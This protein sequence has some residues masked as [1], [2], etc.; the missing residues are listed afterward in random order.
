[1]VL[2]HLL[3]S[4]GVFAQESD[5]MDLAIYNA[6]LLDTISAEEEYPVQYPDNPQ[7]F[8][9]Y[10]D[11]VL[12]Q[13]VVSS[14]SSA[15]SYYNEEFTTPMPPPKPRSDKSSQTSWSGFQDLNSVPVN[16]QELEA[17][18]PDFAKAYNEEESQLQAD[19]ADLEFV[20]QSDFAVLNQDG[21]IESYG[22]NEELQDVVYETY[23]VSYPDYEEYEQDYVQEPELKEQQGFD[24][25]QGSGPTTLMLFNIFSPEEVDFLKTLVG[26]EA[27]NELKDDVDVPTVKEDEI[28]QTLEISTP[29]SR[30][31]PQFNLNSSGSKNAY[32]SSQGIV[33]PDL[34]IRESLEV[35]HKSELQ[36][37]D[38]AGDLEEEGFLPLQRQ[39]SIPSFEEKAASV[40][41]YSPLMRDIE[42]EESDSPPIVE[43]E[44]DQSEKKGL[45]AKA[46]ER[47]VKM[48]ALLHKLSERYEKKKKEDEDAVVKSMED[49]LDEEIEETEKKTNRMKTMIENLKNKLAQS[50][51]GVNN[52]DTRDLDLPVRTD[53]P[54]DEKRYGTTAPPVH[55]DKVSEMIGEKLR[56]LHGGIHN[57][58]LDD[59]LDLDNIQIKNKGEDSNIP[60]LPVP[61][62]GSEN[63][64]KRQVL[65]PKLTRQRPVS[66]KTHIPSINLKAIITPP[67]EA[68]NLS[69]I[70]YNKR[71]IIP[72]Y[73]DEPIP[74]PQP[75]TYKATEEDT[76]IKYLP[77]RQGPRLKGYKKKND[78]Y[79]ETKELPKNPY[80]VQYEE[81]TE[82]ENPTPQSFNHNE[83]FEDKTEKS[84]ELPP[85]LFYSDRH[86]PANFN[87]KVGPQ[88]MP[89]M[90]ETVPHLEAYDEH[91]FHGKYIPSNTYRNQPIYKGDVEQSLRTSKKYAPSSYTKYP[92][93]SYNYKQPNIRFDETPTKAPH[94]QVTPKNVPKTS[95]L[96]AGGL[97][98]TYAQPNAEYVQFLNT[99][100]PKELPTR[101]YAPPPYRPPSYEAKTPDYYT[102]PANQEYNGV[103]NPKPEHVSSL[104]PP[105]R[106][107]V[108]PVGQRTKPSPPQKPYH[109]P[110]PS[111][112]SKIYQPRTGYVPPSSGNYISALTPPPEPSTPHPHVSS[113]SPP[114]KQYLPPK[115]HVST[116]M[117]PPNSKYSTP[118][119]SYVSSISPPKY[120]YSTPQP[121]YHSTT[122][123]TKGAYGKPG[124]SHL[125]SM[126]P[127]RKAYASH[128]L[129]MTPPSN[130]YK[131]PSYMSTMQPP[132]QV[133]ENPMYHSM[134]EMKP[135]S[136]SYQAGIHDH[137]TK[138]PPPSKN[139][140]SPPD[141]KMTK[142]TPPTGDYSSLQPNYREAMKPP[143]ESYDSPIKDDLT[144]NKPP[145]KESY[146]PPKKNYRDPIEPPH[147]SY[148]DGMKGIMSKLSL[149]EQEFLQ[150]AMS[151]KSYL[152]PSKDYKIPDNI[153]KEKPPNGDYMETM[154][155]YMQKPEKLPKNDYKAPDTLTKDFP[156]SKDYL[157]TMY[158]YLGEMKKPPKD[159]YHA[160]HH[161]TKDHHPTKSDYID[162]MFKYLQDINIPTKDYLPPKETHMSPPSESYNAPI[163][164]YLS[165][166][167]LPRKGYLP[168]DDKPTKY[169]PPSKGYNDA[170]SEYLGSLHAPD[171]SYLPPKPKG[172]YMKPPASSY[173]EPLNEYMAK[174][175]A[176]D[177]GYLPP[178][179]KGVHMKPPASSYEKPF[180]DHMTRL[181]V[182]NKDYLPPKQLSGFLPELA[183]YLSPISE[184][185]AS[186][187]PPKT[188]YSYKE[189]QKPHATGYN[190]PEKVNLRPPSREYLT[191]FRP[192]SSPKDPRLLPMVPPREVYSAPQPKPRVPT[193]VRT[194]CPYP[195]KDAKCEY[196]KHQCWSPGTP[197]VDCPGSGL[198]CFNGCV[199]VCLASPS[200]SQPIF[201][202]FHT[203]PNNA[204]LVPGQQN[205]YLQALAS[206][207]RNEEGTDALSDH[208]LPPMYSLAALDTIEI[209]GLPD[210]PEVSQL[211]R[212]KLEKANMVPPAKEYLP[213]SNYPTPIDGYELPKY[214]DVEVS[215][216]KRPDVNYLPPSLDYQI[217][218]G[219]VNVVNGFRVPSEDYLPPVKISKYSPPASSYK[220][221]KSIE[222]FVPPSNEYLPPHDMNKY[223]PPS[224]PY[225][226]PNR[227]GKYSPP[228]KEYLPPKESLKPP[229]S[230]Y[231][232]PVST[233][234]K[235]IH[236]A[237]GGIEAAFQP[238]SGDYIA[239][240]VPTIIKT[241][242]SEN[243][244]LVSGNTFNPPSK[245]YIPPALK[246]A[247]PYYE[248]ERAVF[249]PPSE[250]YLAPQSLFVEDNFHEGVHFQIPSEEY[251]S[252]HPEFKPVHREHGLMTPPE[253]DYSTPVVPSKLPHGASFAPPSEQYV[254]P[255]TPHPKPHIHHEG[256]YLVPPG[257]E[258]IAPHP[259]DPITH[260][261]PSTFHAHQEHAIFHPPV[262]EY[263]PPKMIVS[264]E[265]ATF[266]PPASEYASPPLNHQ[267]VDPHR[268]KY[269]LD[270]TYKPPSKEYLPPHDYKPKENIP[271]PPH[272]HELPHGDL[273]TLV[274]PNKDYLPPPSNTIE[275]IGHGIHVS[276]HHKHHIAVPPALLP[277]NEHKHHP[278]SP[279][280]LTQKE[281]HHDLLSPV[282]HD[283]YH[284]TATIN[285]DGHIEPHHGVVSKV[286][287]HTINIQINIPDKNKHG[288]VHHELPT[289][290]RTSKPPSYS[291]KSPEKH[292]EEV[293]HD[294]KLKEGYDK[295]MPHM[296]PHDFHEGHKTMPHMLPHEHHHG[297]DDHHEGRYKSGPPPTLPHYVPPPLS[298]KYE[299]GYKSPK[300]LDSEYLPP[301]QYLPSHHRLPPK[302]YLPTNPNIYDEGYIKPSYESKVP[303]RESADLFNPMQTLKPP[304]AEFQSPAELNAPIKPDTYLPPDGNRLN[305][306]QKDYLPPSLTKDREVEALIPNPP[307]PE[308]LPEDL[309]EG[310]EIDDGLPNRG[311]QFPLQQKEKEYARPPPRPGSL[312]IVIEDVL[313]S[314][315]NPPIEGKEMYIP[316]KTRFDVPKNFIRPD[317]LLIA[318]PDPAFI[319][320]DPDNDVD[321][322]D[323]I[324]V[325]DAEELPEPPIPETVPEQLTEQPF[326]GLAKL[327]DPERKKSLKELEDLR[328][329]V[330]KLAKLVEDKNEG[331]QLP[332]IPTVP[333]LLTS[334]QLRL[335]PQPSSFMPFIEKLEPSVLQQLQSTVR[336]QNTRD[337]KIPGKPGV[338]YPDFKTIPATDFSCENFLLEG[339]YADTF[340]SCQVSSFSA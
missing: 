136:T 259:H 40:A 245:E 64:P 251:I 201:S 273:P 84:D 271:A 242:Q 162:T 5:K 299:E 331:P 131:A 225:S 97:S 98:S 158:K 178:K 231:L 137:M 206:K 120:G 13:T 33:R 90:K 37:Q 159:E 38:Q 250:E 320:N 20:D 35:Y 303:D 296:L 101:S 238:P 286:G 197:D 62:P 248:K 272:P 91:D 176:P 125:S 216:I 108:P 327:I 19:L 281:P 31:P 42:I 140:Y 185:M 229:T 106:G 122:K 26:E 59:M 315:V 318:P 211:P 165:S 278:H 332:P 170:M 105:A 61:P 175:H 77:P 4:N 116:T 189:V 23:D 166:M 144:Q 129:A 60:L 110:R 339:F 100:V 58:D 152:P 45:L 290:F 204:Y 235:P 151:G 179:S 307:V 257:K 163:S 150:Q 21:S 275:E 66:G 182:P 283:D 226:V 114:R 308:D 219:E 243:F 319:D 220:A 164:D 186:M 291:K 333:S 83:H 252:P 88:A 27:V 117:I 54:V 51:P 262:K 266:K 123:P 177:S 293:H 143:S 194:V 82:Y 267:I 240:K 213:P 295:V 109:S 340:T 317:D 261:S 29:K 22:T 336:S 9:D 180:K 86:I 71:P 285:K 119:P 284:V 127:P 94:I 15:I 142:Y 53:S 118:K 70:D 209:S 134:A 46:D 202:N 212:G 214:E 222:V 67:T 249:K 30:R 28:R 168:P 148:E 312:D 263:L 76:K 24:L 237:Q 338:D 181:N 203:P 3:C 300:Y 56:D 145:A 192:S 241:P 232:P 80:D 280:L 55:I 329:E 255:K 147:S 7:E 78:P 92:P 279:A 301:R 239:P 49:Q 169:E 233:T 191:P 128:L 316:P 289:L 6:K 157:E 193:F 39:E 218:K 104:S 12:G 63:K 294:P 254:A 48:E 149:P 183:S 270:M 227:I 217:S 95:S 287:P 325:L 172:A 14:T 190:S 161:D 32:P 113:I 253:K 269:N 171:S 34:N 328:A 247:D 188:E 330:K 25:G 107:Y 208:F 124:F 126:G 146:L 195:D 323:A 205:L 174:L 74:T 258:Y 244:H 93:P 87:P 215:E 321:E 89:A 210:R 302:K 10:E 228:S 130:G 224:E 337:G 173:E 260:T 207:R 198:C 73:V 223:Q 277:K 103:E 200:P 102:P 8:S 256:P 313:N 167:H 305:L 156:P 304:R 68:P 306:P 112:V 16:D 265:R 141:Q 282:N 133:Y 11:S 50:R 311:S 335:P 41:S 234:L 69:A 75:Y 276:E 184:Y 1:M 322:F 47:R 17:V 264:P 79:P 99:E 292:H 236:F 135:P 154:F 81:E 111:Y 121:S 309:P 139:S 72:R 268:D 196:V 221:P 230:N 96:P 326:L 324:D 297:F 65:H 44:M 115:P 36:H 199:N 57:L 314:Q 43:I 288:N 52:V 334:Q 155:K 2:L 85:T 18:F 298:T 132:Q 274:P 187:I 310:L 138:I 160:P 153:S 246:V